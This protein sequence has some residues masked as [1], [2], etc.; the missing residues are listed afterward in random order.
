[1]GGTPIATGNDAVQ[2]PG[3][4]VNLSLGNAPG[5]GESVGSLVNHVGFIMNNVQEQTAKWKIIGVPVLPGNNR[6]LDQAFVVMPTA[7]ASKSWTRRM[8]IRHAHVHFLLSEAEIPKAQA[9]YAKTFGGKAGNR[10]NAPVVDIPGGQLR[11]AKADTLQAPTKGRVVD[12]FGFDVKDLQVF[13]KKIAAEGIKLDE[14]LRNKRGGRRAHIYHRFVGRPHRV[15]SA[16][17][18]PIGPDLDSPTRRGRLAVPDR[19]RADR[20]DS[21]ETIGFPGILHRWRESRFFVA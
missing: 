21:N 20:S 8:P 7:C 13:I 10:N 15:G 11:C 9:W 3:V 17:A 2:F 12:H 14:P 16:A 4:R 19:R 5:A 18:S 1:M 6:R